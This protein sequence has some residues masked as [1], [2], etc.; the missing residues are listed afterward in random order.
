MKKGQF[1]LLLLFFTSFL[2]SCNKG[3]VLSNDLDVQFIESN[4]TSIFPTGAFPHFDIND[5]TEPD[6]YPHFVNYTNPTQINA[7]FKEDLTNFLK[8]NKIHLV[9]DS[10]TYRLVISSISYYESNNRQSYIDSC[11][12]GYP[13]AYVYA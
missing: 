7:D 6:V 5:Q 12:F 9:P 13:S 3:E 8:K 10:N 11:G 2:I 1:Y 4:N